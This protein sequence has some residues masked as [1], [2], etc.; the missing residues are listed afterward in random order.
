MSPK[1]IGSLLLRTDDIAK[2]PDGAVDGPAVTSKHGTINDHRSD[3]TF[4]SVPIRQVVG[5]DGNDVWATHKTVVL[6]CSQFSFYVQTNQTNNSERAVVV[7]VSGHGP[8]N[9]EYRCSGT[10][11]GASY[12]VCRKDSNLSTH[13]VGDEKSL[14]YVDQ[15]ITLNSDFLDIRFQYTLM[16]AFGPGQTVLPVSPNPVSYPHALFHFC[17][18]TED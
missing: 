17:I 13:T 15:R 11:S 16:T 5:N 4:A 8:A 12:L 1:L 18:Y 7:I 6:R 2:Q 3:F 9:R 10:Q 14:E